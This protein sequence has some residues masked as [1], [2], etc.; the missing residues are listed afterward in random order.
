MLNKS[1]FKAAML[2]FAANFLFNACT[3]Q[4]NENIMSS[5][6]PT[7]GINQVKV[8][9]GR[10]AFKNSE[11]FFKFT[12]DVTNKSEEDL[13]VWENQ[14]GFKSL[15]NTLHQS[16]LS[17]KDLNN[18]LQKLEN[19]NFPRGHLS[20][21]NEKGECL[22]G[23]TIVLYL[24]GFKHFIPNKD[25]NLLD[26]IRNNPSVSKIKGI[27]GGKVQPNAQ[28]TSSLV[29]L[30]SN[31]LDARYQWQFT[32]Q[33]YQGNSSVGPKKFVH[34]L[35]A[36]SETANGL[37]FHAKLFVRTK[38]EYKSRNTWRE[39]GEFRR[40]TYNMFATYTLNGYDI[41][42]NPSSISG[43]TSLVN[44]GSFELRRFAY[45]L[46]IIDINFGSAG[47]FYWST[48]VSG[49]IAQ[50][51]DGDVQANFWQSTGSPLW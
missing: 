26:A 45:E 20:V 31:Q 17:D 30:G 33:F 8:E 13:N 36:W 24:D 29:T 7:V 46:L 42:G 39:A 48:E 28:A 41:W 16:Y 11:E 3:K 22:I 6:A 34:E 1:I 19:F 4:E 27:A 5:A 25:E 37:F 49:N 51:M 32:S 43:S 21:L 12:T 23:D 47:P 9:N 2:I 10:V 44:T 40:I 35:V 38:L 50:I 15:R 14:M 18:D